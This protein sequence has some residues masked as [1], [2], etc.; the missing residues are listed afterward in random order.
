M[1]AVLLGLRSLDVCCFELLEENLMVVIRAFVVIIA[2]FGREHRLDHAWA[3]GSI[4]VFLSIIFND[5]VRVVLLNINIDIDLLIKS[6]ERVIDNKDMELEK[7]NATKALLHFKLGNIGF[8]G[9]DAFSLHNILSCLS[10]S[11]DNVPLV[12]L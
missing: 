8:V 9:R 12:F 4:L 1:F 10:V 11:D 3:L 7:T 5:A 2:G 6:N